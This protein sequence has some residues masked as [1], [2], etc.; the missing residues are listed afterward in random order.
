MF[1]HRELELAIENLCGSAPHD[2]R[3][4]GFTRWSTP[5]GKSNRNGWAKLTDDGTVIF[6]CW[7]RQTAGHWRDG[8]APNVHVI[9]HEA[10]RRAEAEETAR[11][12]R[13][14]HYNE[15]TWQCARPIADSPAEKYLINRGLGG[16]MAAPN[17]VRVT[18]LDYVDE[19][20]AHGRFDVML[21]LIQKPDGEPV[22]LHRTY[23]T[24]G[25][26]KAGVPA[27]RKMTPPSG[28]LAGA[29]VRL[30]EPMRIDGLMTLGVGEGLETCLA[31][32]LGS[33]LPVWSCL[34]AGLLAQFVWP[35]ELQQLVVFG[36][37]DA[38]G[39]G[40]RAA[41]TL[42]ARAC[43]AGLKVRVLIPPNEGNDWLDVVNAGGA[44]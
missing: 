36:D 39:V 29:A 10:I 4:R 7:R 40:Q 6:G 42:A 22:C 19:G 14:A 28:L 5:P 31:A 11:L 30:A 38:N 27:P 18:R 20:V 23:V 9:D 24:P 33:G 41:R 17:N 34:N 2:I 43:A 16:L 1:V 13:V 21:A 8:D 37:H 15:V 32:H 25:G 3:E 44:V 12:K 35:S 26:W